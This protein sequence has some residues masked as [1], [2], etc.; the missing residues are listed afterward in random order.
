MPVPVKRELPSLLQNGVDVN[1]AERSAFERVHSVF[2]TRI[3]SMAWPLRAIFGRS[4]KNV[5]PVSGLVQEPTKHELEQNIK[6][7]KIQRSR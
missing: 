3:Y 6:D 5:P 1:D 4:T 2:R 7:Q